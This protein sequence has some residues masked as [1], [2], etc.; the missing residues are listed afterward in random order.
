MPR[1]DLEHLRELLPVPPSGGDA[2]D[3]QE[4]ERNTELVF[5]ADYRAFVE[6]YGGGVINEYLSVNTPP[7]LD[8]PYGDILDKLETTL[9]DR[10]QQE[11]SALLGVSD[12]P[13]LLPFADTANGDTAFWLRVGSPD[14][15]RVTVFRRQSPY[16]TSRWTLF[17][18]GM[19]PFFIA[20]LVNEIDPF[21]ER[22]STG[23]P[24]EFESWHTE[25]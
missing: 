22:L 14:D 18:A 13:P 8:S 1:P 19:V 5:P 2:V 24:H 4:V 25:Y 23:G 6:E 15:W 20:V 21:S 7:V 9:S 12:L 16:G 11:L 17:D 3:W 10:D